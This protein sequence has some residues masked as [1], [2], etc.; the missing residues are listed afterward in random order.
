MASGA[1]YQVYGTAVPDILNSA[2]KYQVDP[3][4]ALSLA[5]GEGGLNYGAVGDNNSSFG[6][7]QLHV[8][9]ALPPGKGEAWANSPEGIDYAIRQIASAIGTRMGRAGIQAGVT[10]FER[11]AAQNVA[12]EIARDTAWYDKQVRRAG[13]RPIDAAAKGYHPLTSAQESLQGG[14]TSVVPGLD[15]VTGAVSG[16]VSGIEGYVLRGGKIILGLILIV[17]V[18][19]FAI[20]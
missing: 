15:S 11:P 5:Y 4:V 10:N 8:G 9:G 19:F 20:R 1:G 2:K 14:L 12:P 18:I 7:Y 3:W 17:A 6:P 13:G 16:W